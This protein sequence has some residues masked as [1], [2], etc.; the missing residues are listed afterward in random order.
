[1]RCP[2][3]APLH[4]SKVWCCFYLSFRTYQFS[5]P[6]IACLEHWTQVKAFQLFNPK[7]TDQTKRHNAYTIYRMS[8][9]DGMCTIKIYRN[10]LT[11]WLFKLPIGSM[12]DIFT[13]IWPIFMVDG[14]KYTSLMGS[15]GFLNRH[16]SCR[17]CLKVLERSRSCKARAA[18]GRWAASF[19]WKKSNEG[20]IK[21]RNTPLEEENHLP[22][23]PF[24]GSML[25]FVGVYSI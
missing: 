13:H 6:C 16:V 20:S 22:N 17:A 21:N 12:Y 14:G 2:L 25:I 18:P 5:Q 24:L 23:H 1:M 3:K 15:Y 7:P 9:R 19:G 4:V 11:K 8:Y 10:R